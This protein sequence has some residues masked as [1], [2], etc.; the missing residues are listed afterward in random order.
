M[1]FTITIGW[2]PVVIYLLAGVLLWLP[3]AYLDIRHVSPR[4][5]L[6]GSLVEW[7]RRHGTAFVLAACFVH[8]VAWPIRL[9]QIMG[10]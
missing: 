8:V 4:R 6:W 7:R 10:D 2:S 3:L 5:T 1:S 9:L